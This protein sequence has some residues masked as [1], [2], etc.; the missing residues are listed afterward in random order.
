M[1]DVTLEWMDE[2]VAPDVSHVIT[3]DDTPVDNIFSAKQQ[4]LLVESLYTSWKPG[5]PF[6]ADANVGVFRSPHL[7][8]IVP[9]V[10][11]SLDVEIA[12]NWY[13]KEH[14]TY[15]IW[16]FGKPPEI[17]IEVVS[18]TKWRE[19]SS[20]LREYAQVGV[21]YYAIY[22]PQQLISDDVLRVYDLQAGKYRLKDNTF[23]DEVGLGVVLWEGVYETKAA[24]WLR[25]YD[26]DENLLP[27]GAEAVHLERERAARERE[28]AERL[29]AQL[30][31]LGVNPDL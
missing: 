17:A 30:R 14:R 1:A 5:R 3:E 15:F 6:V 24:E 13:V 16:E 23:F 7:P 2:V 20:K 26:A 22:D 8:P 19:G 31:E 9:D 18:N 12:E 4:R 25:W 21:A 11:L 29:A 10:F 27:T 28:R